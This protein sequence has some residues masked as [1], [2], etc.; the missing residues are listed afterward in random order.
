MSDGAWWQGAAPRLLNPGKRRTMASVGLRSRRPQ[1]R[2]L[3]GAPLFSISRR[4]RYVQNPSGSVRTRRMPSAFAWVAAWVALPEPF[5]W[6]GAWVKRRLPSVTRLPHHSTL[7]RALVL[8][9]RH[10]Y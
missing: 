9:Q 2:T 6:V 4:K 8:A 3:S 7:A 5:A 10:L 1:V